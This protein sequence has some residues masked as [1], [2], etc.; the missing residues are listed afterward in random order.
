MNGAKSFIL[1]VLVIFLLNTGSSNAHRMFI[2]Q[3]MTLDI[4]ANYDDGSPAANATVKL[5]QDGQLFTENATD[6]NG[7]FTMVLPGKGTGKW[8]YEI[9]GTGHTE[10]GYIN[11][12]NS[13]PVQ[14]A[15]LGLALLVPVYLAIRRKNEDGK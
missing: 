5:Y 9:V 11:V 4:Y 15:A 14:A 1:I 8:H 6:A 13:P 12:D 7:R 3:R 10:K 2:G